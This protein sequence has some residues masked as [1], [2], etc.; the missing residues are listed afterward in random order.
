MQTENGKLKPIVLTT[1]CFDV[2][3]HGHVDYL[4]RIKENYPD[5]SLYVGIGDDEGVSRL[6]G[7]ER[8]IVP[9]EHRLIM[10]S[11]CHYV[12][13]AQ[14]FNIFQDENDTDQRGMGCFI[15]MVNPDVFVTGPRSPNQHAH[16]YLKKRVPFEIVDNVS[17]F[18]TTKFLKH[19][20]T[21]KKKWIDIRDGS[22][23]ERI[24]PHNYGYIRGSHF[25]RKNLGG[26]Y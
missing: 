9:A 6:K 11:A 14:V 2:F 18:T 23:I 15:D 13:W 20:H 16:L 19:I 25:K 24:T 1:G 21:R 17:D 12:D 3:H 10:V 4:R 26:V 7:T 5:H 8:P 22:L